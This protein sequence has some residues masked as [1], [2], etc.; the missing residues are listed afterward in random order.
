VLDANSAMQEDMTA[1]M[2]E[3]GISTHAR[4]VSPHALMVEE[5][6]P[7]VREARDAAGRLFDKAVRL[8]EAELHL[9]LN[10]LYDLGDAFGFHY[11]IEDG[12]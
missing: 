6:I 3:L 4:P 5:I 10:E 1:L 8:P 12:T 7:R 2:T 9:I 11:T